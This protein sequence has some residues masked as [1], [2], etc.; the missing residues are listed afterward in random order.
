MH[1]LTGLHWVL[2][3]CASTSI[4]LLLSAGDV[5][6]PLLA[7]WM[8][9][10]HEFVN[11]TSTS[12]IQLVC[13]HKFLTSLQHLALV[14]T[15]FALGPSLHYWGLFLVAPSLHPRNPP[16]GF[17]HLCIHQHCAA[18]FSWGCASPI[19]LL[20]WLQGLQEFVG[21]R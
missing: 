8:Q 11:S 1:K 3:T 9:G 15:L 6:H 10:L 4:V 13:R 2:L 18:A 19:A 17:A 20:N 16:S 5:H 7:Y 21:S 12:L 14:Q